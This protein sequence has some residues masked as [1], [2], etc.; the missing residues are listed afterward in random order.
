LSVLSGAEPWRPRPVQSDA[1]G[2][3]R[4]ALVQSR[5]SLL[6]GDQVSLEVSVGP[7]ASLET[8]ELGAMLALD[9]RGGPEASLSVTVSIADGGRLIWLSEPLIAGA[10]CRV[11]SY[12]S[13][14]LVGSARMLRREGLVFGRAGEEC[15]LVTART[16]ITHDGRPLLDETIS[17]ED[18]FVLRS[19]VVADAAPMLAAL[20]LAGIR[21]PEPPAG[22]MQA[23]G[24]A[25]LWREAGDAVEL[26]VVGSGLARR[27][28]SL[29]VGPA[30]DAFGGAERSE[31]QI[32][33][34]RA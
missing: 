29:L 4:V 7:G 25:T 10:G 32:S 20:T 34:L 9:G 27:W 15:G 28:R 14:C 13:V 6:A 18:P 17:T 11:S 23:H 2:W 1:P 33:L 30:P 31:P 8:V 3:A 16:R 24:E 19:P 12:A 22:A 21:D 5:A 26:D